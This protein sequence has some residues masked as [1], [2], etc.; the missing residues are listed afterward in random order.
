MADAPSGTDRITVVS[1]MPP[2]VTPARAPLLWYAVHTRSRHEK[3]VAQQLEE[4]G[5]E[6]FLP[7]HEV[8]RQWSD[9]RKLVV[10]PLFPG[11]L[12]VRIDLQRRLD[13]LKARGA[14]ALIGTEGNPTPVSEQEISSIRQVCL[15]R[16]GIEPYPYLTEGMRIQVV[17][18]PLAGVRGYLV[19]KHKRDRLVISIDA[20]GRSVAVEVSMRDVI[21]AE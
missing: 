20:I 4:K 18:G 3:L 17:R 16:L 7:L 1:A 21:P 15:A 12:F 6:H 2:G 14:V 19:R 9:R 13:V 8:M 10:L 11:Y 5:V